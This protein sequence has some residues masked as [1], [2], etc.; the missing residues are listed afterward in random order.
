MRPR[1]DG[2]GTGA[3]ARLNTFD[4]TSLV[5]GSII[6]ADVYVATA[7]GARLVG[8]ASLIVWVLAGAMA[9]TIAFFFAYCVILRPKVGE[10][11]ASVRAAV[12]PFVGF[13]V[14][15]GLLLAEWFSLAVFPV[16]FTQY[17]LSLVPGI[18]EL[19]KALLKAV[20]IA[21]ILVTNLVGVKTAGRVNDALT[22]AKLAPLLLIV[23]G[24]IAFLGL[25]PA[26]FA[27][28]LSPFVT[29][30]LSAFGR[31]LVLIFWAYAGV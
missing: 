31:A 2:K 24:G 4:V 28:N 21:I 15:W 26:T 29:G 8:P 19:A 3:S 13:L 14:G 12:S 20:F 30:D 6:G 1:G 7:I 10:P 25:Q 22:I 9:M 23:V 27:S 17:F 11:T 5:V 16:A 18:D